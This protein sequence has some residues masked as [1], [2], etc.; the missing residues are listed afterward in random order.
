MGFAGSANVFSPDRGHPRRRAGADG[1]L[2]RARDRMAAPA[3]GK[4]GGERLANLAE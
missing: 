1:G 2:F 3:C 4:V